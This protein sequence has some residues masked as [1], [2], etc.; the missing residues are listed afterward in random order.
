MIASRML[1]KALKCCAVASFQKDWS[2]SFCV[3][4][5]I[6][7][8][9]NWSYEVQER[10]CTYSKFIERL[11]LRSIIWFP[12]TSDLPKR[13][14]R[15][16]YESHAKP[17][18]PGWPCKYRNPRVRQVESGGQHLTGCGMR[19]HAEAGSSEMLSSWPPLE[20]TLWQDCACNRFIMIHPK[21][22]EIYI[23]RNGFET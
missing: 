11:N 18:H 12:Q 2:A 22:I 15:P 20:T 14:P 5:S 1:W 6:K 10:Y 21:M 17:D 16:R 23:Y 7:T 19:R 9:P 4:V 3:I 13:R 8:R